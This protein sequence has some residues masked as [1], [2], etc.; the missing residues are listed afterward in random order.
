M[1]FAGYAGGYGLMVVIDHGDDLQTAYAHL[2]ALRASKR[3]SVRS[4]EVIGRVGTTGSS[5]GNHLHL[6]VRLA[7]GTT[8]P[9][10]WLRQRGL[11]LAGVP[12]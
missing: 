4:G 6:E 9:A 12:T 5:T 8:D 10:A 1:I 3:E 7:S 11:R 2:S